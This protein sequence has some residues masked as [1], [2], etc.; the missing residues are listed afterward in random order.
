[1]TDGTGRRP[2]VSN[3]LRPLHSYATASLWTLQ[4]HFRS[5]PWRHAASDTWHA[6]GVPG[7][8]DLITEWLTV[9]DV[10]ERLH[11]DVTKVRQLL[12]ERKLLGVRRDGV[13]WVPAIFVGDGAILKG[14]PGTL[15]L[16]ADSGFNDDEALRWLFT[17]DGL[18]GSPVQALAENRGTEVKRRAQA[19]AF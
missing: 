5:T 14:L 19:L 3:H 1:L 2:V 12:R 18:P 15:S 16:L 17:D 4:G 11:V 9:P 13:L 10:A 7:I 8:E 6:I